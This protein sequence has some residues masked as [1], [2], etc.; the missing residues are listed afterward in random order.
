MKTEDLGLVI[1]IGTGVIGLW[2]WV[3]NF[4][5]KKDQTGGRGGP[6]GGWQKTTLFQVFFRN[7]ITILIYVVVSRHERTK[8][9]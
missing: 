3:N 8:G 4:S 2:L 9:Y 7:L 6:R 5:R 1:N